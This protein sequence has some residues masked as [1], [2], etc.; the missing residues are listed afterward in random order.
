[1]KIADAALKAIDETTS[2]SLALA[3]PYTRA[4]AAATISSSDESK[5]PVIDMA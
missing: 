2:A 3:H 4:V 5:S 1:M